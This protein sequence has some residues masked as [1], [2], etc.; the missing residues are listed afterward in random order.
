MIHTTFRINVAT[1]PQDAEMLTPSVLSK[2]FKCASAGV[3][4]VDNHGL[5]ADEDA[6]EPD[7]RPV[8]A[9]EPLDEADLEGMTE[10]ERAE[11]L[12]R[13]AA[14][15][16]A[17]T[18][19]GR[20]ITQ[21]ALDTYRETIAQR[22][23]FGIPNT[24][25]TNIDTEHTKLKRILAEPIDDIV[26]AKPNPSRPLPKTQRARVDEACA[27]F[28]KELPC[29]ELRASIL[30]R[31]LWEADDPVA[32]QNWKKVVLPQTVA[33]TVELERDLLRLE[34]NDGF[35]PELVAALRFE[36]LDVRF[37]R[38]TVSI[39]NE[40]T[41]RFGDVEGALRDVYARVNDGSLGEGEVARIDVPFVDYGALQARI[42]ARIAAE[43]AAAEQA[44]LEAEAAEQEAARLEAQV[45]AEQEAAEEASTE[46]AAALEG[47]AE[48]QTLAT[49]CDETAE[50]AD[51][52]D[53]EEL[54]AS[55]EDALAEAAPDE[56]AAASEDETEERPVSRT[57]GLAALRIADATCVAVRSAENA[58]WAE[59]AQR[60][61]EREAAIAEA[62]AAGTAVDFG[63][64]NDR[65]WGVT[66][67]DGT[68]RYFDSKTGEF[69][70]MPEPE[71]EVEPEVEALDDAAGGTALD[72][73]LDD[74]AAGDASSP[75]NPS[76][77]KG[78]ASPNAAPVLSPVD[79]A[80]PACA[81]KAS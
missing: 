39:A 59:V 74:D 57:H 41:N 27:H 52:A 16:V 72:A 75:S 78:A 23:A 68:L 32:R 24:K 13:R 58:H 37:D 61:A 66:Y 21:A 4:R 28:P 25:R 49:S 47:A 17:Y 29:L 79:E 50:G 65:V 6:S 62:Q 69:C 70:D 63:S 7:E 80:E 11:A 71:P 14:R 18:A 77:P 9:A 54:G 33:Q 40:D 56:N 43:E 10:Q 48:E 2:V 3:T 46:Q 36:R 35:D 64:A 81:L 76:S 20:A 67:M 15:V 42:E 12:A 55:D 44:R 31:P 19:N 60:K 51:A 30:H 53:A 73:A 5:P 22:R 45:A 1:E 26:A 8:A 38:F 34:T